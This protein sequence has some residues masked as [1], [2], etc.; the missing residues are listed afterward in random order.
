MIAYR[1]AGFH[2]ILEPADVGLFENL[3]DDE[4]V[5]NASCL[6]YSASSF[7]GVSLGLFIQIS[8]FEIPMGRLPGG[9]ISS[10]LQIE[11]NRNLRVFWF[12]GPKGLW[13]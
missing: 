5:Q 10:H 7:N 13:Q 3:T 11:R 2:K 8:F 6:F 12:I 4:E 1:M 9:K